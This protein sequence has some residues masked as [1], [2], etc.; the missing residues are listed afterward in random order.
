M[1]DQQTAGSFHDRPGRHAVARNN[2]G[3]RLAFCALLAL[4]VGGAVNYAPTQDAEDDDDEAFVSVAMRTGDAGVAFGASA[5]V[6]STAALT[7]EQQNVARFLSR[8]YQVAIDQAQQFVEFAY[9]SAREVEVDPFLILAVISVESAFDPA[10]R[11]NRGAQGLMQVLTRVHKEKFLPFGGVRAAFDPLSN[12]RVGARILK[13]YLERDGSVEGA[14]KAYVGAALRPSDGGYGE[15]VLSERRFIATAAVGRVDVDALVQRAARTDAEQRVPA[16]A[17]AVRQPRAAISV[18]ASD[19]QG[20]G[21]PGYG[22]AKDAVFREPV[23]LEPRGD[24][25]RDGPSAAQTGD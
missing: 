5:P 11:S 10:A 1:Q 2:R 21:L 6:P 25:D 17:S 7:R 22:Q 24:R 20:R 13:T 9:R 18:R 4:A 15:R 8:R 12:I 19:E 23:E 3:K 14:L 16:R